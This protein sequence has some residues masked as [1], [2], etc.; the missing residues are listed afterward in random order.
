MMQRNE[1]GRT[2][3]RRTLATSAVAT[4]FAAAVTGLVLSCSNESASGNPSN[5]ATSGTALTAAKAGKEA[6]EGAGAQRAPPTVPRRD[7]SLSALSHELITR[8]GQDGS[9]IDLDEVQ[10]R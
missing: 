5:T 6:N 2:P 3:R 10:V 7:K 1:T 4:L 9:I 8:Y